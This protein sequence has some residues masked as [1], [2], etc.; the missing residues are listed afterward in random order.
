MASSIPKTMK[1]LVAPRYCKPKDYEIREIPT[2]TIE[3]PDDVLI[4]VHA[5]GIQAGD[6]QMAG[7]MAKLLGKLD[8]PIKMAIEGSG[9]VQA[10]G[11]AVTTLKPGDAVYGAVFKRP[12][13]PLK[14]VGFAAE[15]VV[16]AEQFLVPKPPGL[17]FD[18]AAGLM[19]NAVTAYQN[20]RR[21]LELAGVEDTSMA[22]PLLRGKKV[23]MPAALSGTGNI[24]AQMIKRTFKA[25]RLVS[26]VSTAKLPLVDRLL[27]GVCDKVIDYTKED[28]VREAGGAG[29]FDVVY[30]TQWDLPA[31]VPLANPR[32]GVIV[33]IASAPSPALFREVLGPAN[34]PFWVAWVLGAAQWYYAWLLRG[35]AVRYEFLSG[36]MGRREDVEAVAA[37][38][39]RG[40]VRPVVR[41]VRMAD[42]DE[43]RAHCEL[44]RV[45][46]GGVGKLVIQ[47]V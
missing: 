7:G 35:T 22:G 9:V 43:V 5:A 4:K 45:S 28:V 34:T 37:V 41:T 11:S 32:T 36:D 16:A 44:T 19:G 10:V 30:N 2:P 31:A 42:I 12:I 25:D 33:S 27:P 18:E 8:F 15:Y 24:G 38:A 20:L 46:K 3:N 1:A 40:D 39:A 23:F 13:I 47:V 6:T 29:A 14:Q 17:S 21:A 26:T